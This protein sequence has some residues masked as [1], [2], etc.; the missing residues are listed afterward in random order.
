MSAILLSFYINKNGN[1]QKGGIQFVE[2][3]RFGF[4]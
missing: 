1:R 3:Y 4:C 2:A